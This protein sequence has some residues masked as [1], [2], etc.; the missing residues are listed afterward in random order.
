MKM[1]KLFLITIISLLSLSLVGCEAFVRKFTRKKKEAPEEELVLVPQEYKDT[2]TPEQK[3]RQYFVYWK[4]E[5]DELI[6]AL[7]LNKPLK[8]K[9][10][11]A[12]E[13]IKHLENMKGMLKE[14]SQQ[15]LIGYIERLQDILSGMENDPY[16]RNN[17][18]YRVRAENLERSIMKDCSYNKVKT[19][20]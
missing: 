12:Q 14:S 15:K 17:N 3:Y 9:M 18:F 7:L 13:A 1:K 5:Q 11:S 16:G 10:K 20:L 19:S 6:E 8:K 4:A 2:A